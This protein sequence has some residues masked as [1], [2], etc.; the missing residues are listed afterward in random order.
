MARKKCCPF[1][2]SVLLAL[3]TLI[4]PCLGWSNPSCSA[5]YQKQGGAAVELEMGVSQAVLRILTTSDGLVGGLFPEGDL[6]GFYTQWSKQNYPRVEPAKVDWDL[7][8]EDLQMRL[9]VEVSRRKKTDFFEDRVVPNVK[10][11]DIIHV[12]FDQT[13]DFLGQQYQRGE[14]DVDVSRFFRRVEYISPAS[15]ANFSGV[16][17]HLRSSE[18]DAGD[19][20]HSAW[21]FQAGI[22]APKTHLHE[23]V[24]EPLPIEALEKAPEETSLVMTE[25]YR[26]IN[27]LAEFVSVL[28]L[29]RIS[30]NKR[31]SWSRLSTLHFFDSINPNFLSGIY[32]YFAGEWKYKKLGD[33]FKMGW[34]G[35]RG[36]DAYDQPNLYGYEYRSIS[37][38]SSLPLRKKILSN[39][40]KGMRSQEY[41]LSS[42]SMLDWVRSKGVN[43]RDENAVSALWESTWYKQSYTTLLKR[44]PAY[45]RPIL[46][47]PV[48]SFL[49]VAS[50]RFSWMGNEATKMLLYDWSTDP[51]FHADPIAQKKLIEEQQR[52]L[53]RYFKNGEALNVVLKD[54]VW[55]S[56]LLERVAQTFGLE[57][58]DFDALEITP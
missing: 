21:N 41:G 12:Q 25:H 47:G 39:L 23:H 31:F 7:L 49:K 52:A 9:L 2:A 36:S 37:D 15:V 17:L 27:L 44:L 22:G 48:R 8:D 58:S 50:L 40:Q 32:R 3:L 19:L 13:T 24:V 51:L 14:Y 4:K 20:V 54:F 55:S 30:A 5:A 6:P 46:G 1:L 26:R 43:I 53:N 57:K 10:V 16:E 18:M 56:G 34:V 38:S 35:F 33:L 45:L 29:R 28:K 11:R 42:P